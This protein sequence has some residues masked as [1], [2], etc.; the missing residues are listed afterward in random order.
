MGYTEIPKTDSK[1]RFAFIDNVEKK[2]KHLFA[3]FY[4][5]AATKDRLEGLTDAEIINQI[6]SSPSKLKRQTR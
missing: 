6:Q 1:E 3:M 5:H 2:F 4:E